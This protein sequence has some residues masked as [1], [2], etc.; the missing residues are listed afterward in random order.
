MPANEL[1]FMASSISS[2]G[3]KYSETMQSV[4]SHKTILIV[5]DGALKAREGG[6]IWV[7]I[8]ERVIRIGLNE[9]QDRNCS[10]KQIQLPI[11]NNVPMKETNE[12]C[13]QS[14]CRCI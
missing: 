3:I 7:Q 9:S 5:S 2:K 11:V 6:S 8:N 12:L 14:Y 4:S 10:S 13:A 1:D